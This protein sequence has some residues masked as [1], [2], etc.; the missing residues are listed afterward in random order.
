ME[1]GTGQFCRSAGRCGA[2]R[3]DAAWRARGHAPGHPAMPN[4]CLL[5]ANNL[6]F[7]KTLIFLEI[8]PNLW[9]SHAA[10][11]KAAPMGVRVAKAKACSQGMDKPRS[12]RQGQGQGSPHGR[13]AKAKACSSQ[14]QGSA[15]GRAAKAKPRSPRQGQGQGSPH[16][17]AAKAKACSSQ[18]QGSAHGRA[19][20][21]KACTG[22]AAHAKAKAKAAPMGVLPRPRHAAAKAKAAPMSVLPRPR[23]AQATQPRSRQPPWACC[24]GQGM[25]K[26]RSQGQGSPHGQAA[27]AKSCTRHAAKAKAKA[28]PMGVLPRP[29]QPPWARCQG[30]GM[31]P[32]PRQPPCACSSHG[33]GSPHGHAAKAKACTRHAARP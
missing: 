16:G 26:P 11:A 19:A 13:A 33:Q 17:R 24:Q 22:H 5:G 30:Q 18:G 23:H 20:K 25:R 8:T 7:Q 32:G 14:G 27:K 21:A 12:P 10:K 31:Q 15:H 6:L 2:M 3:G 29:R 4:A 1:K 9:A 28:A